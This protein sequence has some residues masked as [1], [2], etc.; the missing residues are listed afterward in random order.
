MPAESVVE[1]ADWALLALPPSDV[2]R[3]EEL[4]ALLEGLRVPGAARHS[5]LEG[6]GT[7]A[8]VVVDA[9][10]DVLAV[11]D[12]Y[13]PVIGWE[14]VDATALRSGLEALGGAGS[15]LAGRA[16]DAGVDAIDVAH[17]DAIAWITRDSSETTALLGARAGMSFLALSG[18]G[19]ATVLAPQRTEDFDRAYAD[20]VWLAPR[21]L[22]V[23]RSGVESGAAMVVGLAVR[24]IVW[25]SRWTPIDPSRSGQ[26]LES[27]VPLRS[28]IEDAVASDDDVDPWIRRFDVPVERAP[29]LRALVR[30]EPSAG[31]LA[32]LLGILGVDRSLLDVLDGRERTPG[33]VVIAPRTFRTLMAEELRRDIGLL[34]LRDGSWPRRHP[35]LR[36]A[37]WGVVILA[38]GVFGA[39]GLAEGRATAWLPIVVAVL[40]AARLTVY[41]AL[42]KV[43]RRAAERG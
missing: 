9:E 36:F 1:P 13:R 38:L 27:G 39:V 29:H 41:A 8:L 25:R 33:V 40:C 12:D 22:V 7:F 16:L 34:P 18:V 4:A 28:A 21:A 20:D 19:D 24:R 14:R 11:R 37:A 31:S 30:R 3:V 15:T 43:R 32:E 6:E 26:S 10:G 35:L 17:I 2:D 42:T 5:R 23:W